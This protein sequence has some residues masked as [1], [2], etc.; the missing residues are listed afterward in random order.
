MNNELLA[1]IVSIIPMIGAWLV[2]VPIALYL[3]VIGDTLSG[4]ILFLYGLLFVSTIDN[5]LKPYFISKRTN[6]G[7][8]VAILGIVGGLYTFGVIGLI[9]GPL[10]LSYVLIIVDFYRQGKLNELFK[11]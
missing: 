1:I 3:L 8:F 9:L 6:V 4:T 10:V 11:E 5:I 7:T 2:W